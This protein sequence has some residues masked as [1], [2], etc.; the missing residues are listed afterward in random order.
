MQTP[1]RQH[2]RARVD[3]KAGFVARRGRALAQIDQ[4]VC[5]T[6]AAFLDLTLEVGNL[7]DRGLHPR[8]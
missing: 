8:P 7:K 3:T 1:H 2:L 6:F 5:I 4:P